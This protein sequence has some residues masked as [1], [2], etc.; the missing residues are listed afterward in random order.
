MA[1][2]PL[3]RVAWLHQMLKERPSSLRVIDGSWFLPSAKRDPPKEFLQKRIPGARYFDIDDCRDKNNPYEHMIPSEAEFGKY[4]SNLGIT[5]NSHVIVYDT[6][7]SPGVFSAPR[8]WW[9]FRVFGHENVS[10]LDGGLREWCSAGYST[11][12]GDIEETPKG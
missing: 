1:A 2:R 8:V 5:N 3:V 4:V 11:E 6:S 9:T 10:V 7:E 12:S